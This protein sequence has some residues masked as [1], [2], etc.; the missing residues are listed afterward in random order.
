MADVL[1]NFRARNET[2]SEFRELKGDIQSLEIALRAVADLARVGIRLAGDL[3]R[4]ESE[5][6]ESISELESDTSERIASINE[7]KAERLGDISRRIEAEDR[8]RLAEIEQ[9]FED[10]RDAEV[11]ARAEAGAA[12]VAIEA[13]VVRQRL[14]AQQQYYREV[15][16]LETELV[17][18]I[19]RIS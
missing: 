17:E 19:A 3:R 2:R 13:R 7:R 16:S 9:A 5:R 14:D 12:I 4:A 18:D 11:E 15:A 6:L 1:I 8:R 10:A